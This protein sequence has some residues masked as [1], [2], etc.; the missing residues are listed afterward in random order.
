MNTDLS[1]VLLDAGGVLL[2]ESAQ[3]ASFAAAI[4]ARLADIVPGYT[5]AQYRD[6]IAEAVRCHCPRTY[7]YVFW[8][9]LKPDA[10]GCASV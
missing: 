5:E 10:A 2:D 8:K 4:T 7:A 9:Y 3:E 6:D 1:T